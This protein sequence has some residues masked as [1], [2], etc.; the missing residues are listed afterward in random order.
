MTSV[1]S[2]HTPAAPSFGPSITLDR[3]AELLS[4][5][6][7]T[8]MREIARDKCPKPFKVGRSV[9]FT[10]QDFETYVASRRSS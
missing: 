5:S 10:M 2:S 7:R 3:F 8:I 6:K 1:T 4:V 9:R